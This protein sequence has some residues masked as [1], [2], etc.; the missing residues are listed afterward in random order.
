[1]KLNPQDV[2]VTS[3]ATAAG[4]G[5]DPVVTDPATDEPTPATH[6]YVCPEE[7]QDCW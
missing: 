7:T 2:V 3:F 4:R 5:V 1:V 6:C